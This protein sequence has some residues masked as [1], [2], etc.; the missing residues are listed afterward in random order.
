MT[1]GEPAPS[2]WMRPERAAVGRPAQRSRAE[3]T[4]AAIVCLAEMIT[5][6]DM[7]KSRE[8]LRNPI[9]TEHEIRKEAS[10]GPPSIEEL[11][12]VRDKLEEQLR[13]SHSQRMPQTCR[14]YRELSDSYFKI[15]QRVKAARR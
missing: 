1:T 12:S 8:R 14:E 2:I 10:V 4:A 7:A 11:E 6:N 5:A 13:I 9:E 3:I 15:V